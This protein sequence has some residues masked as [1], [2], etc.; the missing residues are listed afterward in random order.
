M[1]CHEPYFFQSK[2][3]SF[4]ISSNVY[5]LFAPE[6]TKSDFAKVQER[7]EEKSADI[8]RAETLKNIERMSLKSQMFASTSSQ[9]VKTA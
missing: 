8:T 1:L 9:D 4:S 5:V 2:H 3:L 6:I 7:E